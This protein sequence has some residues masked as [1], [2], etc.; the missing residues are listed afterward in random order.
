M[1][2]EFEQ[3]NGNH[4][5]PSYSFEAKHGNGSAD[6]TIDTTYR[7]VKEEIPKDDMTQPNNMNQH[8]PSF[9]TTYNVPSQPKKKHMNGA[10]KFAL[11]CF[12]FVVVGGGIG[13]GMFFLQHKNSDSSNLISSTPTT[14][15]PKEKVEAGQSTDKTIGSTG[16]VENKIAEN[17]NVSSIVDTVMPSIV[18]ITSTVTSTYFGQSYD[19]S[20]SGS[21]IIIKKDDNEI[22]IVTNNHVVAD[23]TKINV[24]FID[25][26]TVEATVKGTD[27]TA[28]LAVITIPVK[29]IEKS[30][31]GKISVATLGDS[32]STVVGE[33]AIAIG[34]ALGYG[35]SVTVGY[36]SAKNR[37]VAVS[38][39]TSEKMKLMQTDAAINP[40]NS[41][42]ALLNLKGEVIG[43]NSAKYS[44][45]SV[46]SMG[47]AI[48]ITSAVPIINDLMNRE[49]LESNEKGYL[50]ITGSSI[51]EE[52]HTNYNRPYGVLVVEVAKDSAA[53]DAG[54]KV[55]DIVTKINGMEVTSIQALAERVNSYR[56]GTEITLTVQRIED[57]SYKE[58]E[59]K[60]TLKGQETLDSLEKDNSTQSNVDENSGNVQI[61]DSGSNGSDSNGNSDDSNGYYKFPWEYFQ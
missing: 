10:L 14:N 31:L 54:I 37:E 6:E 41:G 47:F 59:I 4:S 42:G 30:T 24:T 11:I 39:T 32:D 58:K 1:S 28:D 29:N 13:C 52:E 49:V 23:A 57:S 55:N 27:S 7:Y 51:T 5:E 34:N 60:V 25:D 48:P 40:G 36:V 18:Q 50:G 56:I 21:G 9:H 33:M 20:G 38:S 61:P 16:T 22:L 44:D 15:V 43:I 35:Q 17:L 53:E 46:E 45:D 8:N 19:S 2:N 3:E 26:K 12:L